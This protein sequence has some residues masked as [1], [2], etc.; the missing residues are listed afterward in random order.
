MMVV[1]TPRP[2]PPVGAMVMVVVI[3]QL[4]QPGV[5]LRLKGWR[6]L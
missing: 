4:Q 3:S 5:I 1:V 2:T 6:R